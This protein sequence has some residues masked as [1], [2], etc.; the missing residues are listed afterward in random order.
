MAVCVRRLHPYPP[1]VLHR[2]FEHPGAHL[3]GH[4]HA[5]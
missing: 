3:H 1:S 2:S 5:V 4:L